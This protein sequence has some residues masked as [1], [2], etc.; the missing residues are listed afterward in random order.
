MEGYFFKFFGKFVKKNWKEVLVI[1]LGLMFFIQCSDLIE[2]KSENKRLTNNFY[3]QCDS[4]DVWKTK[5]GALASKTKNMEVAID[6]LQALYGDA[7][8]RIKDLNIKIKDL[9]SYQHGTITK[10]IH[11]TVI[12]RDTIINKGIYKSGA[13][14]DGCVT[15]NFMIDDSTMV[16]DMIS[17]DTI[18]IFISTE[19]QGQWWKFW[20]FPRPRVYTTTT[21]SHCPNT[22]VAIKSLKIIK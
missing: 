7:K 6:E 8:D 19:K 9:E 17:N 20:T 12:L 11:D 22:K 21:S 10:H 2:L 16:F 3:A 18:D 5:S 15:A 4:A 13:Y 14:T 1:S